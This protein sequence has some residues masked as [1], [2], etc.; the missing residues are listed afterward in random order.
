MTTMA[1]DDSKLP[2]K[3]DD[4]AQKGQDVPQHKRLAQGDPL[5]ANQQGKGVQNAK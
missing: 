1:K 2:A 5:P 3:G 4:A